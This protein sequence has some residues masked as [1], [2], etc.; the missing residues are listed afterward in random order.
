MHS[1]DGLVMKSILTSQRLIGFAF[2]HHVDNQALF[3]NVQ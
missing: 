2:S 3:E 1:F